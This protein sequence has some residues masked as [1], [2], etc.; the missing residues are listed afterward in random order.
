MIDQNELKENIRK[1]MI[2]SLSLIASKEEQISYQKN[3]SIA[4]VAAEIFAQWEDNYVPLENMGQF[5]SADELKGMHEFNVVFLEVCKELP[6]SLPSLEKLHETDVWRK[7][8]ERASKLMRL[9]MKN[10]I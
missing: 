4:D 8:A 3:V 5:Y 2:S 9:L 7:Y 6:S 10:Q 1:S